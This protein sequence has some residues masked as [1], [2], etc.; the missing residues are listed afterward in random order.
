MAE[1]VAIERES[2]LAVT[3]LQGVS[4]GDRMDY[5]LQ[6]ATELGAA[7]IVCVFCARSV[8]RL[9]SNRLQK[10]RAHWEGVIGAA[11]EQSGRNR[12]PE[13]AIRNGLREAL[14]AEALAAPRLLLDPEGVESV[15]SV[16]GP[17]DRAT[18][19]V[20]PEGGLSADEKAE[21]AAAAF[22]PV[23]FGP[24]ILRTETAGSAALT[25][26]QVLWGDLR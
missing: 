23:R 10:R 9:D 1:H 19:L 8:T 3:L 12:L 18:L 7:R 11:C 17:V 4:R 16:S 20:G 2:H 13:L 24:R 5:T 14:M 25:A 21:A 26:L 15:C 22:S 6:K